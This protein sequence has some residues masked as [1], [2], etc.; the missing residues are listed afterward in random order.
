MIVQNLSSWKSL[1]AYKP[2]QIKVNIKD[3]A[4]L[5]FRALTVSIDYRNAV[6]GKLTKG[7]EICSNLRE[8]INVSYKY[9]EI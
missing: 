1:V 9:V 6:I 8:G 5:D 7:I 4:N 2:L 3:G